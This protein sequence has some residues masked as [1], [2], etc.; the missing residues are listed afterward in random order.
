M[1]IPRERKIF[2]AWCANTDPG[3]LT[4]DERK[5]YDR[6][7]QH[8]IEK[9]GAGEAGCQYDLG[10]KFVE[11]IFVPYDIATAIHWFERAVK[12]GDLDAMTALASLYWLGEGGIEQDLLRAFE[13]MENA[14]ELGSPVAQYEIARM[15]QGGVGTNKDLTCAFQ[16]FHAAACNGDEKKRYL[17]SYHDRIGPA[18]SLLKVALFQDDDIKA[19]SQYRVAEALAHG[20]GVERNQLLAK[21]WY[22]TAAN[23]GH[24]L[25]QCELGMCYAQGIGG[26][27]MASAVSWWERAARQGVGQA[28][29]NA[30]IAYSRGDGVSQNLE[31]ANEWASVAAKAGVLAA[32]ILLGNFELKNAQDAE[33][34]C[35]AKDWYIQAA[36]AH[37]VDGQYSVGLTCYRLGL[38]KLNDSLLGTINENLGMRGR[39]SNP[40]RQNVPKTVNDYFKEALLWL[41]LAEENGADQAQDMLSALEKT[42]G[43]DAVAAVKAS[44]PQFRASMEL[45]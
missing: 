34:L 24:G 29:L 10:V 36:K 43:P 1:E 20:G 12:G 19:E 37:D 14:A 21:D 32:M 44:E 2:L 5:L 33:G 17:K 40:E 11:G 28:A 26:R 42:L 31:T 39:S 9:A 8:W 41:Y 23:R 27:D 15:Y 6:F 25:A 7:L 16:W 35:R 38:M 4:E 45:S 13:L 22:Q 3:P 18:D 30:S